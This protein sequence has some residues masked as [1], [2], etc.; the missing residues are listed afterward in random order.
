MGYPISGF[1]QLV[2]GVPPKPTL[3]AINKGLEVL[4]ILLEEGLEL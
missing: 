1:F 2:L 3:N 4:E